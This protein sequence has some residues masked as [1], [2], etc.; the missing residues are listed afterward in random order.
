MS[1]RWRIRAPEYM[2]FY[3]YG[4]TKDAFT[5]LLAT[6]GGVCAICGTTEWGGKKGPQVDHCHKTGRVR[7]VLCTSC[8]NG[9]GRFA[10]DPTRLRRAADYLEKVIT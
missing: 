9:L 5:A 10:D 7:G 2:R 6:Q 8:N 1:T 4:I 3:Q